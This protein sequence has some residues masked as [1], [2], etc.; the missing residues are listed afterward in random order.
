MELNGFSLKEQNLQFFFW[1]VFSF[2]FIFINLIKGQQK[3][4]ADNKPQI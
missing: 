1:L 4:I 2:L 3:N